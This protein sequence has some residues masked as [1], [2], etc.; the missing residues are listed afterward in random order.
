MLASVCKILSI[1]T[2]SQLII[3]SVAVFISVQMLSARYISCTRRQLLFLWYES[4]LWVP[5]NVIARQ[6]NLIALHIW[7]LKYLSLGRCIK[8]ITTINFKKRS[9]FFIGLWNFS[10]VRPIFLICWA[11]VT[12]DIIKFVSIQF[13]IYLYKASVSAVLQQSVWGWY[14][15]FAIM[16][17]IQLTD[18]SA[19]LTYHL[20]RLVT[21]S[22]GKIIAHQIWCG[23]FS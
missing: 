21:H 12:V 16:L 9:C 4:I 8:L 5:C 17:L 18:M 19:L 11:V 23:S 22:L 20:Q 2:S 15:T 14:S 3:Y 1:T 10:N 7:A 13:R 6:V